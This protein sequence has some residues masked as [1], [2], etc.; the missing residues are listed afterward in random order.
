MSPLQPLVSTIPGDRRQYN[1]MFLLD[2]GAH[3]LK[4][5]R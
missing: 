3:L 5:L 4:F 1:K 2:L